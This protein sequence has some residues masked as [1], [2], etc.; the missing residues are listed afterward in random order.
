MA[1]YFVANQTQVGWVY[2]MVNALIAL[3]LV[4]FVYSWGMLKAVNGQRSFRNLSNTRKNG[5][6]ANGHQHIDPLFKP[7][8][9][10]ED[11]PLEVSLHFYQN[12][13]KPT[14]L[15]AGTE[16]CPLAA[17]HEQHQTFFI[18]SL[19]KN[20]PV[21]LSYKTT[22]YK[23][24]FY[25]FP[26]QKL[27]SSGPFSFFSSKRTLPVP[28]EILIYPKYHPLKRLRLIQNRGFTDRQA[29]RVGPSSEVI[30][31][32]EYRS[33]DSLRKIHWRSTA[34][35]NRLVV[36]EF[37]DDDH[38]TLTVALD[39]SIQNGGQDKFSPF[40]TAIRIAASLGYYAT[41][42]DIPFR[43]VG[44]SEQW[45]PPSTAL[46]WWGVL[47]YLARV[48]PDGQKPLATVLRNLPPT[49]FVAVLVSHP[50][51]TVYAELA[52]LKNRGIYAVAIFITPN[53]A[54]PL[55]ALNLATDKLTV[56]TTD[57]KNWVST[58]KEL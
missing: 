53:G 57:P 9:Y 34:R 1:L 13:L 28:G 11:D 26:P 47:H 37:S 22:C 7:D 49:P 21:N 3:L 10:F 2:I 16:T 41:H 30:G 6:T 42:H 52:A 17:P 51:D 14:F 25:T 44:H 8:E 18:S 35:T 46:S 24:G 23:R 40:E 36:K 12:R 27:R 50:T 33:G 48:Q 54:T 32:R 45:Q 29:M 5:H 4:S 38:Q 19:F 15:T 39:L 55:P 20:Q 56:K 58:L 31:T 43:L